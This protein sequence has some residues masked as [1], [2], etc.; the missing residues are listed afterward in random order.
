VRLGIF[1]DVGMKL[2]SS[3]AMLWLMGM[4]GEWKGS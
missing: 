3:R 2:M 4:S 1:C